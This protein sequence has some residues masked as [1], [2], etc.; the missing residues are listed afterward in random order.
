VVRKQFGG[1]PFTFYR[2]CAQNVL[3][4][5]ASVL[6]A[7]GQLP[8]GTTNETM[9]GVLAGPYLQGQKFVPFD[10]I[11][12]LTGAQNPLW[13]RDSVDKMAEWLRRFR[14]EVPKHVLDGFGH[15]DLWWGTRSE[16]I[17]FPLVRD[18]VK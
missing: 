10:R 15:Q 12:L 2:Q 11:T 14:R 18:A 6:D 8:N 3:R 1:I 9:N 16:K 4:G 13:H 17:V 7:E 5:F